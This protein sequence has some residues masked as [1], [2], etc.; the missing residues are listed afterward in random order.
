MQSSNQ[1]PRE[2]GS[3]MVNGNHMRAESGEVA[4]SGIN[5]SHEGV[6]GTA[7]GAT[8]GVANG[9]HV[10][11]GDE[12]PT[13]TYEPI[14]IIGCAMRLP[15]GVNDGEALWSLLESKR[16]GRCLVP[17]DRYNVDAFYGPGKQGHV[18]SKYGYFLDHLD[19]AEMDTSMWS[20][21]K[22]EAS[23]MDPQQRLALE[24]VFECL[25]SS[26]TTQWHGKNIGTYFGIFGE[27]WADMQ[28]KETQH[29]GMYRITGYGDFVVANRISYEFGFKGPSMV[30]RTA[31]SSS[32]TGLH[33]ACLGIQS[34]EC[35]SAIVGSTN[36]ILNPHMTIAMTEQGVLSPD[37]RCKTFDESAN[38]YARA[39]GVV[40]VHIKKL[41]H[42]I[43]D[44]DPIRA[45]IQSSCVNS[46]G[47]TAG[48]SLP[49]SAS[50][51]ALIRR[52]HELAGISDLS[53][54]AMIECH[55]TGTYVGDPLEATAVGRVFGD[56]GI[57]IG[58]IKP[59]V[60]HTEGA[61]GLA[62]VIKMVLALERR[63]IPPNINF[64]TPSS[65]IPFEKYKLQVPTET[66][67]WPEGR[68]E[69]VGVNSYGIGGANAHVLLESA[70]TVGGN[71]PRHFTTIKQD[72]YL[73]TFSAS[74]TDALQRLVQEHE[75]YLQAYPERLVD[76][77]YTLN[78]RREQLSCRAFSV[79]RDQMQLEP[80]QVSG[81]EKGGDPRK[82]VYVFTG[83]GAQ[84]ARMGA[85]LLES[86]ATFRRSI[87]K[88]EQ[89]LLKFQDTPHWS[90]G[91]ELMKTQT[92][93]R[94]SM[95]EFSQ[96]CCTALQIALVDVFRE[97]GLKPTAVVGH[98]SGEIAAAYSCEALTAD[99][100]I[101]IAY[102]RGQVMKE[103]AREGG[104]AAIGL[105]R[106]A[107]TPFLRPGVV[108]GCENSP[109]SV[110]LSGDLEVVEEVMKSIKQEF[111][112]TLVRALKV[113]RAYH[114]HHMKSI[115][116]KYAAMLGPLPK[117]EPQAA[118]FSSVTGTQLNK[119]FNET[120]WTEN[121]ISPVLFSPA[122]AGLLIYSKSPQMFLEVGP[123]AA[124]AGP[125]RQIFKAE[126]ASQSEYVSA[127]VRGQDSVNAL[128]N[129]AGTMFQH[130]IDLDL[131]KLSPTGSTLVDLP[132]Y[133][134]QRTGK[135]WNESR[136]SKDWRLRPSAKHDILGERVNAASGTNPTW[137]NL[138]RLEDVPWI[139]D[140]DISQDIVFPGAGYVAMAG[141]AVR[142]L[143]GSYDFTVR[144][145]NISNALV[146]HETVSTEVITHLHAT[147]LTTS[148]DSVWYSFDISS[149]SGDTWI[150]HAVGQVRGG[151]KY[152]QTCPEIRAMNRRMDSKKW[153]SVM[154]RVGLNYGP[155][156]RG[157]REITADVSSRKAVAYIDN[158]VEPKE[159]SYAI[160]P[161]TID[162]AFQLFSVAV[163]KGLPRLFAQLSV[164]TYI[165]ELY[166]K[167]TCDEILVEANTELTP[168]GTFFGDAIGT[169]NGETVFRL[170]NLKLSPLTDAADVRG[171]DPHAAVELIWK[172]DIRFVN[173]A[174]L[175]KVIRNIEDLSFMV[176]RMALA[177]MVETSLLL[178]GKQAPYPFLYKFRSWLDRIRGQA[179][180]GSYPNV[181]DCEEISQMSRQDRLALIEKIHTEAM[182][183]RAW[184]VSTAVYRIFHAIEDI[185]V[186]DADA[187]EILM[188]DDVLTKVYDFGQISDYRD[189]FV[190]A[191]HF[192]P[193]LKVLEVG[194][195]T[196]GL[197]SVV[198]PHLQS[199]YPYEDRRYFSYTYTDISPGFFGPAKERFKDYDSIEYKVLD[200]TKDPVEQGFEPESFDMIVASNVIHATPNLTETLI[201]IRKLLSPKGRLF[202]QELSPPTKWINF[203]MG[204]LPGWWLGEHDGRTE[205][206]YIPPSKWEK[207]LCEA[208][209]DGIDSFQHDN[210]YNANM[211]AVATQPST[212][213][214]VTLLCRNLSAP[215]VAEASRVLRGRGYE[216]DFCK[217]G[218]VPPPQQDIVALVDVENAFLHEMDEKGFDEFK[219]ILQNLRGSGIL[220]VTGLAQ[221]KCLDPRYGMILG[222]ART[223]RTELSLDVATMELEK[224]DSQG[225]E[226]VAAVL[227]E[228]QRRSDYG[229]IRPSL[230]WTYVDGFI[231]VGRY[232]WISVTKQLSVASSRGS[233]RKLEVGKRGFLNSLYWKRYTPPEPDGNFVQIRNYA[234]GLNFKDILVTA[235]IIEGKTLEGDGLGAESSGVIEKVGPDV[236]SLAPGDRCMVFASGN[237]ST[238]M[239]TCESNCVKIPDGLSFVEAAC[240]ATV[241]CT[242]IYSLI[243][244]A[245]VEEG[246]TV[247][248]HSACGGVGIAAIQI[249]RILGAE[250]F[251][252]VGSEVK[253]THLVDVYGI[254]RNRIFNSRDLTFQRDLL[255]ATHGRGV[256]V[257]LNSLSGELLHASWE[258][259]APFGCMIEIG[260]RD[261]IGKGKLAL[262][263]FQH[264]R[265]YFGVDF[266]QICVERPYLAS[267]LLKKTMELYERSEIKPIS[268]IT[269][270]EAHK[271]EDAMRF[272][273]KG[274]HIG[275]VVVTLPEDPEDL[276]VQSSE[277]DFKFREDASYLLVGGLGGLGQAITIWMAEAGAR[278]IVFLSRSAYNSEEYSAFIQ[279][280]DRLGC[281]AVMIPGSVADIQAVYKAIDTAA[282]PIRGVMQASMVLRD[283]GLPSMSFEDWQATAKPKVQGTWNLHEAFLERKS[284]LDFFLLFSSSSGLVGQA[285]QAN[286][287]AC[288]TFLDAF[289]QFRRAQGLPATVLDIGLMGDIGYVSRNANILEHFHKT[290][291]H[292]LHEQD[293]LD[294]IQLMI[295]RS[296][297][298]KS[299]QASSCDEEAGSCE[300][301][302]KGQ[303]TIGLR[304]TQPLSVAEN[305]TIW[306]NDP[307][308]ASYRNMESQGS[309]VAVSTNE[310]LKQFIAD[311]ARNPNVLDSDEAA[312]F[313]AT[314]IGKT[315]FGFMMR[316]EDTLN[317]QHSPNA[318][319][320]DSLVSIEL[321]NWFKSRLG[322]EITVLEILGANS[323][324]ELGRHSAAMLKKK[325]APDSEQRDAQQVDREG[326]QKYLAMKAP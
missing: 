288:N 27:D 128:L 271:V 205:E 212:R 206:P 30:I 182:D 308:M 313:L 162:F 132:L 279:E 174:S 12:M 59:N 292:V 41:S 218:E 104:M 62:G 199:Q 274:N 144:D 155:R 129:C 145:V 181:A 269:Q 22:T 245:R 54:T 254:P 60:G 48:L 301:V 184:P 67:S 298:T 204:V 320:V 92:E 118:F 96:P 246:Q 103:V 202:M 141:E 77:S 82:L 71:R 125:L 291:T 285:G 248:I 152:E 306:K 280:L 122:V 311:A 209:F 135:H 229:E 151:F 265:T 223:I 148:L 241:Y 275:K 99:E 153:Y 303:L 222:M 150:K 263:L 102:Y 119:H 110:T 293:L 200:V 64:K 53:R 270:F 294:S 138:L 211:V 20:M 52:S 159:S 283:T 322:F 57:L 156:F 197:T 37:G 249:C 305:R 31:C 268:P 278:E 42:A 15:G 56:C 5:I 230:E 290:S 226:A 94:L 175:I 178:T 198:L 180:D 89:A 26:G 243:D 147:R 251:C 72:Q 307:R 173:N 28:A 267:R 231:Q 139:R 260:K 266:A 35:E 17:Q 310:Q 273:Q 299:E 302:N 70:A 23:E 300:Y 168:R 117:R 108:I 227:P 140:H 105:G 154:K 13:S 193:N 11:N 21:T 146:M 68:A 253:T 9:V 16:E 80:L 38:G 93:S 121:L 85:A 221:V 236:K 314:E 165:E 34:G 115:K 45:V 149:L 97:W 163:A 120:Y 242:V 63:L 58:S 36:L 232:H 101:K 170:K 213:P 257:V 127:L 192:K 264:N 25:Q 100:A 75:Q 76:L 317:L 234:A 188:K 137:R 136:L 134:W 250:I 111:P 50:H 220:W 208:G 160:H 1:I 171:D 43:R 304:S 183:T 106:A 24:V 46:D 98:S 323:I 225:W 61:S 318:L 289:G 112:E 65:K 176:E 124:L 78:V 172:P 51:E 187:L 324:L 130:G 109:S 228:F 158:I 3:A 239:T 216:L 203:I 194:A 113:D 86:N 295:E 296:K 19:L 123:H 277:P 287:A 190:L 210:Q 189:L 233:A 133:P 309:S 66:M 14:A 177:C 312:T 40:A 215:H 195:G 73:L 256:D 244:K 191:S 297:S 116:S 262:D 69:R 8:N 326:N 240:M 142:Q 261:L 7:N 281:S 315:V 33:E 319:A 126:S 79:V 237:F 316:D 18:C 214:R 10:P 238:T 83:Q 90:L 224:F 4:G 252:T 259:V 74:S 49:S 258:C 32:L 207:H 39:E 321:R 81:L 131:K 107:V 284:E 235:G 219:Q 114:S 325:V 88:M 44:N 286:Y 143:T 47:K 6:N 255:L 55:G 91:D 185:F 272:M 169:S 95:A 161:C 201:N 247:L 179:T 164:P 87:V 217:W 282:R 157:L 84:W 186:G 2:N 167:P 196:G 276:P 29:S 166:I